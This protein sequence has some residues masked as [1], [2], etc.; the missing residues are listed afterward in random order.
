VADVV[1]IITGVEVPGAAAGVVLK[2]NG[3]ADSPVTVGD[4]RLTVQ[5]TAVV[6]P[7]VKVAT[8]F[9][10]VFPPAVILALVGLQA[11]E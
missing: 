4:G 7:E 1:E 8:T 2:D 3:E 11:T 5:A 10:V 6:V 9:G